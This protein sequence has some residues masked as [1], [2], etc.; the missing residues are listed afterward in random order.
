MLMRVS[1]PQDRGRLGEDRDAALALQ[2]VGVHRALDLPLVLAEGA[3]LLQQ[4][5][6]QRGFAVVDVGD[7]GDVA[8]VHETKLDWAARPAAADLTA[9]PGFARNIATKTTNATKCCTA[10]KLW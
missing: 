8:Q 2:V 6:D 3:G 4:T 10:A 5:V 7:D 9:I 1:L